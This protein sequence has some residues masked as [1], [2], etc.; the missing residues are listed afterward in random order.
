MVTTQ[1]IPLE[2]IDAG[3]QNTNAGPD[4]LL[5]KIK[6]GETIWV[7]HV[8]LHLRSSDWFLHGHHTNPLYDMVV[9]HVVLDADCDVRNTLGETIP[10]LQI[11]IPEH[12]R[13][14]YEVLRIT[15]EYPRCYPILSKLSGFEIHSW[16]SALLAERLKERLDQIQERLLHLDNDWNDCLFVTIARNFGFGLNGDAFEQ[17]ALSFS[18]RAVDKHRDSLMQVEALFFGQAGLLADDSLSMEQQ[19]DDYWQALRKEYAYL[20][21]KFGLTPMAHHA[22]KLLRTRPHNF[23]HIRLAQLAYL[24]HHRAIDLSTLVDC[25]SLKQVRSLLQTNTSAYWRNHYAFG[26]LAD[27]MHR[28][29]TRSTQDLL[30]VNSIIPILVAYHRHRLQDESTVLSWYEDVRPENNRMIR[31]WQKCK[32]EPQHAGDTQALILLKKNYCDRKRCLDCRFGY[33]YLSKCDVL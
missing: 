6:I 7:G 20:A 17:W 22:W 26:V 27:D 12:I 30:I 32:V 16:L 18:L 33:Y 19:A 10:Q 24:Y 5:S 9:L 21:H 28:S 29:I 11:C 25:D 1:S 8:E 13:Q 2:V 23:P 15:A 14:R 4:F 3:V 31:L